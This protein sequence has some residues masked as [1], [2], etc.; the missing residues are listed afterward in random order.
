MA[1]FINAGVTSTIE[2]EQKQSD[3]KKN[4]QKLIDYIGKNIIGSHHNTSLNT[5][6]G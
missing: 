6:F 1:T 5:V 4:K 3:L 2:V